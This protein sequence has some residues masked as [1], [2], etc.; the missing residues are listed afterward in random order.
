ML[1][2]KTARKT[3]HQ[4]TRPAVDESEINNNDYNNNKWSF[5]LFRCAAATHRAKQ[6]AASESFIDCTDAQHLLRAAASGIEAE[7]PKKQDLPI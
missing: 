2:M 4:V 7:F 6:A 5:L 3:H 1:C